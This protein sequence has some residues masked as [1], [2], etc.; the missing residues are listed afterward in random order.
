M[1]RCVEVRGSNP[2][3]SACLGCRIL[4]G[5]SELLCA[6]W[7]KKEVPSGGAGLVWTLSTYV[8]CCRKVL[9]RVC[10]ASVR[11]QPKKKGV[12]SFSGA[13]GLVLVVGVKLLYM[14]FWACAAVG[15]SCMV[16]LSLNLYVFTGV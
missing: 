9:V 4:P 8:L 3:S 1:V 7:W 12:H 6:S 13:A 10:G 11:C 16:G 14:V 2:P 15:A 5:L